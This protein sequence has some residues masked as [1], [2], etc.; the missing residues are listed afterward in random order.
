MKRILCLLM[1]TVFC[2]S[3]SGVLGAK[4]ASQDESAN[5][6]LRNVSSAARVGEKWLISS[7]ERLY[8]WAG[9]G[10]AD[11]ISSL[12]VSGQ[13]LSDGEQLFVL[14]TLQGMLHL[15]SD[16]DEIATS[17]IES[18]EL[19]KDPFQSE[20]G[21]QKI[22]YD[23]VLTEHFLYILLESDY[24]QSM[25]LLVYE[26]H[27]EKWSISQGIDV[28]AIDRYKGDSIIAATYNATGIDPMCELC[29][30]DGLIP[31]TETLAALAD[32][33]PE[34]IVYNEA[35]NLL[36]LEMNDLIYAYD[37][38]SEPQ[39]VAREPSLMGL[40]ASAMDDNYIFM[41]SNNTL[42]F[43]ALDMGGVEPITLSFAGYNIIDEEDNP[44]FA[45]EYP[46]V[47]I[48]SRFPSWSTDYVTELV[49]NVNAADIY[50]LPASSQIYRAIVKKEHAAPLSSNEIILDSVN[51]MYPQFADNLKNADGEIVAVPFGDLHSPLLYGYNVDAWELAD[52]G[53]PPTSVDAF[54]DMCHAFSLRDDLLEEGWLLS[55]ATDPTAL[56]KEILQFIIQTY[57]SEELSKGGTLS[58]NTPVFLDLLTKY[59]ETVPA[60]ERIC[61]QG[62]P[63]PEGGYN[64]SEVRTRSLLTAPRVE[65]LPEENFFDVETNMQFLYLTIQENASP[66]LDVDM[67]VFLVNVS[68]LHVDIAIEY[69][70]L[71]LQSMSERV[72]IQYYPNE[73]APV[74]S[75][76]YQDDKVYYLNEIAELE[77]RLKATIG[78]EK[79]ELETQILS[80][81]SQFDTNEKNKWGITSDS[82]AKFKK[83]TAYMRTFENLGINFYSS[84]SVELVSLLNQYIYGTISKEQFI[85]RYDQMVTMIM[86]EQS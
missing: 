42:R 19:V 5:P 3:L 78:V 64:E 54:L 62:E 28:Y 55:R 56:K 61:E 63:L 11:L 80:I 57:I 83:A 9:E 36:L 6:L 67:T 31:T 1:V 33:S 20:N 50:C 52:M 37:F 71:Y 25:D 53:D 45:L 68:S 59:E 23:L 66:V 16:G 24:A 38:A 73:D 21:R 18:Y 35:E 14:D 60:L 8:E 82:I 7:E 13:L 49:A 72:R 86:L 44:A 12:A 40:W 69:L 39:I 30:Y 29:Q 41:T 34:T 27:T 48:R 70:Q 26:Y 85:D 43:L 22:I 10:E 76:Y 81:E 2:I 4:A 46:D 32:I 65:L 75:E 79:A 47:L 84:T 51:Q 17:P 58:F 74:L 15:I 77:S